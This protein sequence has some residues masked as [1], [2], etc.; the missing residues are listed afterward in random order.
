MATEEEDTSS[1]FL[2]TGEGGARVPGWVS[3]VRVSPTLSSIPEGAFQYRPRLRIVHLPEGLV[4][5]G[6]AAFFDC[7][8]LERIAIPS[9]IVLVPEGCF[10]HCG[11]L[12]EITLNYGVTEIG[13]HAFDGC[14]SLSAIALPCTV[15]RIGKS[16]FFNSVSNLEL[17]ESIEEIGDYALSQCKF[18]S[19]RFPPLVTEISLGVL[20]SCKN[21]FTLEL[22][23]GVTRIQNYAFSSCHSLRNIA[24]PRNAELMEY[25]FQ[26]CTDLEQ[27]FG[28]HVEIEEELSCRFDGLPI[29]ELCYFLSY[30]SSEE[31]AVAKLGETI[32]E[33]G[34]LNPTGDHHD[35]L[36][37]TP[38]HI[39]SCSTR[40]NLALHKVLIEAYPK[41]LTI[42][43]KWNALPLL[44]AFWSKAPEEIIQ[45]LI[46]SHKTIFPDYKLNWEKMLETL[47]LGNA[48]L[49]TIQNLL[50]THKT[51]FP[52][53]PIQW[54]IILQ[55]LAEPF[56]SWKEHYASIETF[57]YLVQCSVASRVAAIGLK[58]WREQIIGQIARIR[59]GHRSRKADLA[60][61][62]MTLG[63]YEGEFGKLKGATSMLELALWKARMVDG[64]GGRLASSPSSLSKK[65]VEESEYRQRCR[66][67]CRADNVIENVLPFLLP[68]KET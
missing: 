37:M 22:P 19:L 34:M 45:Y 30:Y 33:A 42:T 14:T 27:L 35:R 58:Q 18:P 5:I 39:I 66:I 3:H 36:G 29:H 44:Y 6:R 12:I 46:E 63:Y 54:E 1:A 67:S 49:Q 50:D 40:P 62:I 20:R 64:R 24:V 47:S 13:M 41:A 53:Q 65:M 17:P 57:R 11:K 68:E 2:Y 4:V 60:N 21:I 28:S 7:E 23:L 56:R 26:H 52:Q 31:E 59:D 16:A 48:P 32:M 51:Y 9:T 25:V 8:S 38:L 61:F 15:E 55:K 10:Q 43:D